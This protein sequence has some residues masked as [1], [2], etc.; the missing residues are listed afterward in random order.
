MG[1]NGQCLII[2]LKKK[3]TTAQPYNLMTANN[4]FRARKPAAEQLVKANNA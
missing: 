2:W 4:N 1:D 3:Q